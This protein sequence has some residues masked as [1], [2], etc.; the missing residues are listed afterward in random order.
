MTIAIN[1]G[2][3]MPAY[4]TSMGKVLLAA[5]PE[6]EL[7]RYLATAQLTPH[8]PKTIADADVLR[9]ELAKVRAQCY[10]LA[11]QESE[12][13]LVAIAVPVH[14]RTGEVVAAINLSTHIA[15][16]DVR[17]LRDDLLEPL[18]R[19]ARAIEADLAGVG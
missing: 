10:A 18:R 5:L 14:D 8:R 9:E 19:A 2:A 16:R 1:V 6:A 13:G 12:D 3:R 15:R 17:S 7:E 4:A 11:D